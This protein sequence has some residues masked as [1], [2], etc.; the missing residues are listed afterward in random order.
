[1]SIMRSKSNVHFAINVVGRL[2]IET[3]DNRFRLCGRFSNLLVLFVF[4][5]LCQADPTMEVCNTCGAVKT[6]KIVLQGS[7]VC[8]P[9]TGSTVFDEFSD[10]SVASIKLL[11]C[12]DV[13]LLL[14]LVFPPQHWEGGPAKGV[15]H[16]GLHPVP[17]Q[18]CTPPASI[19][20][21]KS[22]GELF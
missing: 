7:N 17:A 11:F 16:I 15:L 21:A 9:S 19:V 14:L 22:C 13:E 6:K 2:R 18:Q 4:E 8:V 10:A 3:A 20:C 1:M 5:Q 12:S